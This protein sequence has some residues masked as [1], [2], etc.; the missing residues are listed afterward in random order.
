MGVG[1][2]VEEHRIEKMKLKINSLGLEVAK[3][4][5][6]LMHSTCHFLI[7]SCLF[8]CLL[9]VLLPL[10]PTYNRS[11]SLLIPQSLAHDC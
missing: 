8:I 2:V 7:M 11:L 4:H 3:H 5:S 6:I 10:S 1:E 9:S